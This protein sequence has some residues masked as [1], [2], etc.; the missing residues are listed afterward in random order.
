MCENCGATYDKAPIENDPVFDAVAKVV[1][2]TEVSD[3]KLRQEWTNRA[4]LIV[5]GTQDQSSGWYDSAD[6]LV[7][8]IA[9]ELQAAFIIGQ[10][11]SKSTRYQRLFDHT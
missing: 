1:A 10:K 4:E 11:S 9:A 7:G 8:V 5:R 2:E 6:D 3:A